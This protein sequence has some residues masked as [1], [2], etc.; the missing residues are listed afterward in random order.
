MHITQIDIAT[1]TIP[2][3]RPFVTAVRRT[4]AVHDVVVMIKTNTG[5]IGYGSAASTPAITGDTTESI[6]KAIQSKLGP[7]LIGRFVTEINQLLD[8]NE[9]ALL[10]ST[11]AKAA[12]DMA[13]HDLLAQYCGVPLYQ[14][15]GGNKNTL[16]SCITVSAG[17]IHDMTSNAINLVQQGHTML[18]IKLGLNPATDVQVMQAIRQHVGPDINLLVDANQ[19]WSYEESIE[20][21]NDFSHLK[22]NIP[23]VEQPVAAVNL[24]ALQKITTHS[25]CSIF[26]DEACFSA[27]DALNITQNKLCDGINIKLMKS[28]GI[29]KAKAIYYITNTAQ[30]ICMTGCMLESPIGVAAMASFSLA[31]PHIAYVDL[32]PIYLIRDNYVKGGITLDGTHMRLSDKPGLGIEGFVD[33]LNMIGNIR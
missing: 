12:I 33:G 6:I 29:A 10:K 15:L 23:M 18:K 31:M 25:Q 32:D 28:G 30:R 17:S 4:D 27:V 16:Q 20:I 24:E 2:L 13:L 22:L 19:G 1:L 9:H 8:E 7:M 11:S 21:L 3:T 14:L 5:K 26:A